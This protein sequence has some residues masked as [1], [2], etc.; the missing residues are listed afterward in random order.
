MPSVQ[1]TA[2]PGLSTKIQG[3]CAGPTR[4]LCRVGVDTSKTVYRFKGKDYVSWPTYES[5]AGSGS[6]FS[7]VNV[8]LP[9]ALVPPA[10][11]PAEAYY[12]YDFKETRKRAEENIELARAKTTHNDAEV[13]GT[14]HDYYMSGY[15][16]GIPTRF[17][18]PG[19][20]ADGNEEMDALDKEIAAVELQITKV[21]KALEGITLDPSASENNAIRF[22]DKDQTFI[23]AKFLKY[24]NGK[25]IL[26]SLDEPTPEK[27]VRAWHKETL[28]RMV[29]IFVAGSKQ[30]LRDFPSPDELPQDSILGLYQ[31]LMPDLLNSKDQGKD[32]KPGKILYIGQANAW[33]LCAPGATTG[34]GATQGT[35]NVANKTSKWFKNASGGY[36]ETVKKVPGGLEVTNFFC[37]GTLTNSH[38]MGGPV[39]RGLQ[40]EIMMG[41]MKSIQTRLDEG[42]IL[43]PSAYGVIDRCG[44]IEAKIHAYRKKI[45]KGLDTLKAKQPKGSS[46]LECGE[47]LNPDD[48]EMSVVAGMTALTPNKGL[49]G[50]QHQACIHASMQT[51]VEMKLGIQYSYCVWQTVA[52]KIRE[53]LLKAAMN[54]A[55]H[56]T[57]TA[58]EWE[59][60]LAGLMVVGRRRKKSGSR[61]SRKAA[62]AAVLALLLIAVSLIASSCKLKDVDD[63][64][65]SGYRAEDVKT[66]DELLE[67]GGAPEGTNPVLK[68][69]SASRRA[70]LANFCEQACEPLKETVSEYNTELGEAGIQMVAVG[71][72]NGQ[73]LSDVLVG[74]MQKTNELRAKTQNGYKEA[75]YRC[76]TEITFTGKRGKNRRADRKAK[77]E[78]LRLAETACECNAPSDAFDGA[79]QYMDDSNPDIQMAIL[80]GQSNEMIANDAN[81]LAMQAGGY[82][83][84]KDGSI[85]K[86]TNGIS[87]KIGTVFTDESDGPNGN[88]AERAITSLNGR[89]GFY[90]QTLTPSAWIDMDPSMYLE[91]NPLNQMSMFPDAEKISFN[92][93]FAGGASSTLNE[94][95][96]WNAAQGTPLASNDPDQADE[97]N[98]GLA[99]SGGAGGTVGASY[100]ATAAVYAPSGGGSAGSTGPSQW[101]ASPLGVGANTSLVFPPGAPAGAAQRDPA[102]V[103]EKTKS[104]SRGV[105]VAGADSGQM[106][107]KAADPVDY[108]QRIDKNESIFKRASQRYSET[109]REWMRED[110]LR[111]K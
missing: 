43:R 55:S 28:E 14:L 20:C 94:A 93:P 13:W 83:R 11:K 92:D 45:K 90:S 81:A 52:Q 34:T 107:S 95:Q 1:P 23:A 49:K 39:I 62:R 84:N 59:A 110:I 5:P 86:D 85:Q 17:P 75:L 12:P 19:T 30:L 15:K 111:K 22:P 100:K 8:G 98:A 88:L 102:S 31:G 33:T 60:A 106:E 57:D 76:Q 103:V 27:A 91:E 29:R 104:E 53:L 48:P 87:Q 101:M 97:M 58:N 3:C 46:A 47:E 71:T 82:I 67:E 40:V 25:L 38:Y 108:F 26:P 69:P 18:S 56:D 64:T 68:N 50:P 21:K 9:V 51:E 7:Y 6:Y 80:D 63:L 65:C 73:Q 79:T 74:Q 54:T 36:D 89:S 78:N 96:L 24:Y 99:S 41:L 109:H 37:K 4:A 61:S 2:V 72:G 32:G 42:W 77:E 70:E 66:W 16:E 44:E 105:S 35:A 10:D